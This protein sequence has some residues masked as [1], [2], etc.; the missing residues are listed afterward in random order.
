M[1]KL[2]TFV[3]ALSLGMAALFS[4][5]CSDSRCCDQPVCEQPCPPACAPNPECQPDCQPVCPSP[6]C[7]PLCKVL[8][9]CKHP[10]SN[11]LCC[12]DGINVFAKNP[13][14]C[15]LGDQYPLEFVIEACDSVCD[16]VVTTHLPDGV[17][18]VKST[19]EAK[20]E[21]KKLTWIIGSMD[22][23][24]CINAKVWLK[25]ECEGELCACFCATAT[26]VRFCS[27]LCAKPVLVCSKCGPEEV[28]PGDPV[29]YTVTVTNRGSCAAEDVVVTDNVPDGLEH[30]SGQRTVCARLGTLQPC[31]TKTV[32]FNFCA[33][34]R[35]KVCNTVVVSACNADST[36]CQAN[37][38]ICCCA[39][40]LVKTGPKEVMIG[41]NADFQ[42]VATNKGD[43]N[44]TDVVV[45]DCAPNSTA[46]VSAQG[47][48]INGNQAVW[49]LKELKPGE[50]AT[51]NITLNTCTPGCFTNRVNL[52][53]CQQCNACAE[54]TTRW[55]GRP[56]LNVCVTDENDP[57]CVGDCTNYRINV[58]NQGHEAD[59]NVVVVVK[60]P[61]EI[62][63]TAG[64]GPTKATVSGQTVT[65]A[66]IPNLPARQS[67]EYRVDAKA[68]SSGDARVNVEVSSDS[69]RNPILTQES[70]IVN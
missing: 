61:P 22:K 67:V 41:K 19:P 46:I 53:N 11:K 23:G 54:A 25:C 57:V 15:M 2:G 45:S 66:P 55:K 14:L 12:A 47:A 29:T 43:K 69:I 39:V 9:K 62:Q 16:V 64:N 28:C 35:G 58:V 8:P 7:E 10:A 36:S 6:C 63:P 49:R 4:T 18:F 21:G 50:K 20:V 59:S 52:T 13:S 30:A 48:T 42:I 34:K 1:N 68:K 56:A 31:E 5:G 44:L 3:A 65:F 70:T 60:F 51:F 32:C 24:Q 40:D 33:A 27:L 17:S 37:T 38:C 26:P